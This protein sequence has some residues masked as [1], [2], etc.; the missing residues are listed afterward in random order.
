M[1]TIRIFIASSAELEADRK[2]FRQFLSVEN[3]RLHKKGL[4]LELV[5]WENFLDAVSQ[6]SLQDEYNK[7]LEKCD[8]VVCLFY[9]KAGKYTQL[10]FE[11][12]LTNFHKTG[13]PM[14]YTYFK[15]GALQPDTADERVQDMLNFKKRLKE[16]G[17]FLTNY[18]SIEDLLLQFR[19]QLDRLE[20]KGLIKVK[21]EVKMETK[22][23]VTKYINTINNTNTA[24]VEGD[25]NIINQG[26]TVNQSTINAENQKAKTLINTTNL[27]GNISIS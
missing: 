20:D 9:T 10:E 15:S 13:S 5:Q 22:A 18:S 4:Y 19:K 12:A 25:N 27:T 17:H 14:I 24:A 7:E 1:E 21:D 2:A 6:T 23:A 16:I 26:G 11:K 3:D 8:I